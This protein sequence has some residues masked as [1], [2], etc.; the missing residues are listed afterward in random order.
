MTLRK[1][2]KILLAWYFLCF[3]MSVFNCVSADD[4]AKKTLN[5]LEIIDAESAG[6]LKHAPGSMAETAKPGQDHPVLQVPATGPMVLENPPLNLAEVH[7][8]LLN[9]IETLCTN[10]QTTYFN[11]LHCDPKWLRYF[12]SFESRKPNWIDATG[13]NQRA[14]TFI[15]TI[16]RA[17]YNGLDPDTYHFKDIVALLN[18]EYWLQEISNPQSVTGSVLSVEDAS[19][20]EILLTDAFFSYGLHLSEGRI[21]PDSYDADW[22]IQKQRKNLSD[23]YDRI[24]YH[25]EMDHFVSLLEPKHNG[26]LGLKRAMARYIRIR[27]AGGWTSISFGRTLNPGDYNNRI[28][29]IK[30]RLVATQDL[31]LEDNTRDTFFDPALAAAVKRFQAR[32]GLTPDGAVGKNTISVLN[33]PV[34]ERISRIK[35]NMERWRWL[36]DAMGPSYIMVNTAGFRIHM[37]KNDQ[38]VE[39]MRAIV[40]KVDRPTPVLSEQITYLEMNPYWNIPHAIAVNDI[41]PRIQRN[42]N[43][44]RRNKIRVFENWQNNAKEI[45]PTLVDWAEENEY[46]FAFKLQ[47][48]P[49]KT[50]ALGQIKF[51]FPNEFAIY[52]HDTPAH[53]LFEKNQRTFSSGCVRIEKPIALAQYLLK[54]NSGWDSEAIVETLESRKTR[55]VRLENPT[56]VYLLYWTAWVDENDLLHFSDDVY[57]KDKTHYAALDHQT[58]TYQVAS[59]SKKKTSYLSSRDVQADALGM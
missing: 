41:L 54:S 44:L 20:L 53:H 2:V 46:T 26:Y 22:H 15:E 38:I 11:A 59:L 33:T 16:A 3:C 4:T 19:K 1:A 8:A 13:P 57:G 27:E 32:H 31:A 58:R 48:A 36:P 24:L 52:L 18:K 29:A 7:K 40:G 28:K 25:G 14:K 17:E 6:I 10:K 50:N 21:N 30:K 12:Y 47:Q 49:T 23:V 35:L 43:Y 42:P 51:M 34:E 39:S 9:V 56:N 5:R 45:D 55:M 37:V